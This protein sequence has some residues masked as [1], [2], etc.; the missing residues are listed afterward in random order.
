MN[1]V[2]Q[3]EQIWQG[4][5]DITSL[6]VIPDWGALIGL[7]PIFLLI[8]VL[9]PIL[10]LLVLAWFVY[11]VRKPRPGQVI[12][13]EAGPRKAE[14]GADGLPV[15]P[16]GEPICFRDGLIYPFGSR[17]CDACGDALS[18]YCPKCAVARESGIDACPNCG[19]ILKLEPRALTL[20]PAGP[21]P[22]GAAAA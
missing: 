18:V 13:D 22:G 11:V 1:L 17:R 2:D 10:S 4:I 6:F 3:L 7:L 9:G 12:V 14:I 21:P 20:R 5:L 16:R 8:L 15:F 19:L